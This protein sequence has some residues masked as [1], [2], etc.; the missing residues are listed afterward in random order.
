MFTEA[1]IPFGLHKKS[2]RL[3]D[4]GSVA[5]GK[6]CGCICPSCQTP[7]IARQGHRAIPDIYAGAPPHTI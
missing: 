6:A 2:N 7:L 4:V 3:V 1:L 5:K